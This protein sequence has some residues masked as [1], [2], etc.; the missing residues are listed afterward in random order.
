[1]TNFERDTGYNP[2]QAETHSP[3]RRG[4]SRKT[5]ARAQAAIEVISGVGSDVWYGV[6]STGTSNPVVKG[7]CYLAIVGSSALAIDGA[8]DL[9][10][11][12]HHYIGLQ[13][14]KRLTRNPERKAKLEEEI[15]RMTNR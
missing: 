12:T 6:A 10:K 11:G 15:Y 13:A 1:M 7:L 4:I 14:W 8:V 9:V 3:Q 5:L 2:N